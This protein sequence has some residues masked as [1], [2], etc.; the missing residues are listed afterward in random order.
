M[1]A[2]T[3]APFCMRGKTLARLAD[4]PHAMLHKRFYGR[5][6]VSHVDGGGCSGLEKNKL[7][8][9]QEKKH[10]NIKMLL[11]QH[12]RWRETIKLLLP[13]LRPCPTTGIVSLRPLP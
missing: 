4:L 11:I 1:L 5:A 13:P 12:F 9:V 7:N 3:R 6:S 8:S 2:R 10:V